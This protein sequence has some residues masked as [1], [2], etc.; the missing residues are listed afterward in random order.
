MTDRETKL[1]RIA[2]ILDRHDAQA[3]LLTTGENLAWLFD[4][5]RVAVPYGGAP[6]FNA[7]IGRDG[8][9]TVNVF[10]NELDRVAAE[11]VDDVEFRSIP[12]H[13][14]LPTE[15]GLL[16]TDVAAELRAAR[17]SLLPG[18]RARYAELG[19]DTAKAVT[20]ALR[21]ATSGET[22]RSLAA[23][24]AC[25]VVGI[26]AEPVVM[27]VAGSSRLHH[28][29]PLPTL[30]PLGMNTMV[31][32]GARR[33]GLVA[34]LTRWISFTGAHDPNART[35]YEVEADAFAAT[36]PGRELRDVLADIAMSYEHHGLGADTWL[37]HHQG[38][39]T[40]YLGR[41]PRATPTAR[42]LVVAGQAFAWN[43]SIRGGKVE[44][45]V[46]V[47]EG[48]IDVLT[49]DPDWPTIDVRGIP[50]PLP[51]TLDNQGAK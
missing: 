47:D 24:L 37:G 28:R 6:V 32:V 43:P 40:G 18:E 50:R 31:A 11:E 16:D 51:L 1:E 3:I 5:A 45:T 22:E 44:D 8:R 48:G 9:A 17:A 13:E 4:G 26:G 12:W 14:T 20:A 39:P 21:E 15:G 46:I 36:V 42:E 34:S 2:A 29:H 41:D 7:V 49:V 10:A 23:R 30:A 33:H 27:L 38:G 25:A 19:A 35:L